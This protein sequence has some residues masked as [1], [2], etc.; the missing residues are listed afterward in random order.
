M[1]PQVI[2]AIVLIAVG[3]VLLA[4]EGITYTTREPVAEVGPVKVEKEERHRL[5]IGPILGAIA[6]VAGIGM[7]VIRRK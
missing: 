2:I 6:I 7:L 1:R 3:L 4:Y 5:P